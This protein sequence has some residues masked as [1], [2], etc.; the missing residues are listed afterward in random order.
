MM[1]YYSDMTKDEIMSF[2]GKWIELEIII[3]REINQ[4]QKAKYHVFM[5]VAYVD[6]RLIIMGHDCKKRTV[7]EGRI[8]GKGKE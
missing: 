2:V 3:L 4:V 6:S 1:E 5:H 8:N 7:G